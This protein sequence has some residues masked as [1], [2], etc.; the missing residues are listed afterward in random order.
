MRKATLLLLA[1][2]ML[3]LATPYLTVEPGKVLLIAPHPQAPP[4]EPGNRDFKITGSVTLKR[5]QG[6]QANPDFMRQQQ[7]AGGAVVTGG[8]CLIY[9]SVPKPKP[10]NADDE[11]DRVRN[12]VKEFGY[13]APS[14]DNY[15]S[16]PK[17][18]C[19]YK[20]EPESCVRRPDPK[21]PI[22]KPS[23]ELNVRLL[24]DNPISPYPP[25]VGRPI[26]WRV[27]SCQNLKTGGCKERSMPNGHVYR[28]GKTRDFK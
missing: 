12:G 10:C 26:R 20:P 19:W 24:F 4:H 23:L 6:G 5:A 16:P 27:V 25:G 8:G 28:Y 3:G 2:G 11:C 18:V 13:C 22:G 9:F 17:K 15:S 14:N 7:L 1:G 21:D